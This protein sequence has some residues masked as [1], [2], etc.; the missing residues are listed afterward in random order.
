MDGNTSKCD[1]MSTSSPRSKSPSHRNH[2]SHEPESGR[3]Q[4][5]CDASC[6]AALANDADLGNG[7]YLHLK[8]CLLLPC[9]TLADES[10]NA[11]EFL[12]KNAQEHRIAKGWTMVDVVHSTLG[13]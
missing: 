4:R 12:A 13:K 11:D 8:L 7:T 6:M 9:L 5:D 1:D 2:K 3:V 10:F